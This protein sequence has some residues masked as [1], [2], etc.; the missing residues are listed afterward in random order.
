MVNFF[1]GTYYDLEILSS[2]IQLIVR[3]FIL[4]SVLCL[5]VWRKSSLTDEMSTDVR[6]EEQDILSKIKSTTLVLTSY[7]RRDP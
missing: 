7:F 3:F 5:D 2:N 4:F 6:F 1:V